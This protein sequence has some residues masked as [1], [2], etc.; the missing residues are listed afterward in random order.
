MCRISN[1]F[2]TKI[3]ADMRWKF[4]TVVFAAS[5]AALLSYA[6]A[7]R[8]DDVGQAGVENPPLQIDLGL[9]HGL[10]GIGG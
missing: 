8:A 9:P 1:S 4:A 5:T 2:D 10:A 6:A 7:A 3:F